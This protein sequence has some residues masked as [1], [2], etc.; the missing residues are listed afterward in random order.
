MIHSTEKLPE[1][2]PAD[3]R[4]ALYAERINAQH[5]EQV[6]SERRLRRNLREA[7]RRFN[8]NRSFYPWLRKSGFDPKE[9]ERLLTR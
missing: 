4:L 2:M 8:T 9:V 5:A 3:E 7:R 6:E 1:S